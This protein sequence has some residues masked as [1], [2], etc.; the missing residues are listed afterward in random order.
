M[1][2]DLM[3]YLQMAGSYETRCTGNTEVDGLRISTA[4]VSDLGCYETAVCDDAGIYPVE[5]Y[6]SKEKSI[7]GHEKW[8]KDIIG[9]QTIERIHTPNVDDA[10][11][12]TLTRTPPCPLP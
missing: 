7:E 2:F 4:F 9:K 8:T 5:R 11:T 3:N 10:T 12:I 1:F 6:T